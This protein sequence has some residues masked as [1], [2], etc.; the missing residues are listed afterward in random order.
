[1]KNKIKRIK[2]TLKQPKCRKPKSKIGLEGLFNLFPKI[3]FVVIIIS[4]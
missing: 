4:V 3:Y 2:D 1:M